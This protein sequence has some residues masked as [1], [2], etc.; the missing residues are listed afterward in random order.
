MATSL[1]DAFEEYN[2]TLDSAL[3]SACT[4][5]CGNFGLDPGRLAAEWEAF[6]M[7]KR[8]M[9]IEA[10]GEFSAKLSKLKRSVPTSR[11]QFQTKGGFPLAVTKDT[12]HQVDARKRPREGDGAAFGTP[13]AAASRSGA[14]A[15]ASS[16]LTTGPSAHY[17]ERKEPGRVESALNAE[18]G[19]RADVDVIEV[20]VSEWKAAQGIGRHMWERLED[21]ALALDRRTH[22]L[23]LEICASAGID[24]PVNVLRPS[25]EEITAVGRI[26][27]DSEGKIN[28][29]S[30]FLETTRAS[31]AGVRIKLELADVPDF[32]IFRGQV[33]VVRGTNSRGNAISVREV[34][35][36]APRPPPSPAT[37]GARVLVASGPY[38]TDDSLTYEPMRDLLAAASRHTAHAILLLGP[39]VDDAHP[40]VRDGLLPGYTYEQ[41]FRSKVLGMLHEWLAAQRKNGRTPP[42]IIL[43]PSPSDMHAHPTFPQGPLDTRGSRSLADPSLISVRNPATFSIGG[44]VFALST[45]D[46]IK[47]LSAEECARVSLPPSQREDRLARLCRQVVEQR[48]FLPVYPPPKDVAVDTVLSLDV[49][50]LPVTPHILIFSSELNKFAKVASGVVCVN[51]GKL[52]KH[53]TGGSYALLQIHPKGDASDPSKVELANSI[54]ARTCVQLI[55]I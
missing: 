50:A 36:A 20:D 29:Q 26:I 55:R 35:T 33:I 5:L 10:L 38:T 53:M 45:T 48:I 39:F 15:Q 40:S 16:P 24:E 42:T 47:T 4:S 34:F 9:D 52:V 44:Y 41:F 23:G 17:V 1:H 31:S 2:V 6:A 32:V 18:L 43:A 11:P 51:P 22:A 49:G 7:G 37:D 19:I 8:T 28:P 12:L 46:S 21:K 54:A 30:V 13:A 3:V 27:C 25:V 14:A